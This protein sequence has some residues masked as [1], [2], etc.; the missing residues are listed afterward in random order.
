[1][2]YVFDAPV[3]TLVFEADFLAKPVIHIRDDLKQSLSTAPLGFLMRPS[4][5]TSVASRIRTVLMAERKLALALAFL[6]T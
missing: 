3:N 6:G 4:D 5:E 1:V 2:P